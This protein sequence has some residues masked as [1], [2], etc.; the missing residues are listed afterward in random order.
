[1]QGAGQRCN[2]PGWL[3]RTQGRHNMRSIDIHAHLTPQCYL[4]AMAQGKTWHGLHR[5]GG[6]QNPR[7]AWTPEQRIADMDSLGVDVQVVS[8]TAAFYCYE[9][10]PAVTAAIA[11]DCNN[12]VRQ[13]T[14]DYPSRF[15][16]FCTLPMQ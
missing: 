4:Q 2:R 1:S 7:A 3:L 8:S 13:M 12:E 10:E 14:M 6:A 5:E 15:A 11:R 16:G 9:L